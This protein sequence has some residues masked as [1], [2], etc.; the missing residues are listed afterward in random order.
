MQN[1]IVIWNTYP[2]VYDSPEI[3]VN[4]HN[5]FW[6]KPFWMIDNTCCFSRMLHQTAQTTDKYCELFF[7]KLK[8]FSSHGSM[9]TEVHLYIY[10]TIFV[11]F[12]K[13]YSSNCI[14]LCYNP[15]E[16]PQSMTV[17]LLILCFNKNT[18]ICG[19]GINV[20]RGCDLQNK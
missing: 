16:P 3:I 1:I 15:L 8:N 14:L 9:E 4:A 10:L 12:V 11:I 17:K 2:S 19:L 5:E 13:S 18:N 6:T 7:E 20:M